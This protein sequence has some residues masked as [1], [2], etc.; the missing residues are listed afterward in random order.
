MERRKP[1]DE[2]ARQAIKQ[3]VE[4]ART[5]FDSGDAI[6]ALE[7]LR[8]A[9]DGSDE[10]PSAE[11]LE[12]EFLLFSIE[13]HYLPAKQN[14]S[15]IATLRQLATQL[16]D[17][18]SLAALHLSAARHE[19]YQGLV[20]SAR[21]HLS[22]AERLT[23]NPLI[24][25]LLC[26]CLLVGASIEMY[27][28]CLRQALRASRLGFD[29]ALRGNLKRHK[30]GSLGNLGTLS[31]CLGDQVAARRLLREGLELCDTL[32]FVRLALTDSLAATAVFDGN[33]AEAA[34][35][36][37]QCRQTIATQRVP[38]RSW[39]DLTHQITRCLF[40]SL[41]GEW[42]NIVAI[43]DEA[44]PELERRHLRT[45]RATLLAARAKALARLGQHDAANTSLVGAM[46]ACPKGAVDPM[47]HVETA[48][49]VCLAHRG[50]VVQAQRH[51]DRA[52]R[53]C[54]AIEHR[55]LGWIAEHE[56]ANSP[57]GASQ[58][59]PPLERRRQADTD[60][61]AL[62]L[63]NAAAI[64]NAGRSLDLMAERV[65][66]LLHDTPL[67]TRVRL[68]ER[69]EG[70]DQATSALTASW[71]F[72]GSQ[73]CRIDLSNNDRTITIDV[74]DLAS[75]EEVA[76]VKSVTDLLGASVNKD[77]DADERLWPMTMPNSPDDT[78]FWSPRMQELLRITERLATTDLPIL[79]TGETGTGKEVFARLIHDSSKVRRGPF[80]P[81]NASAIPRDLVE[82]QL[83]GHRRGAFT[84]AHESSAGVIRSAD[85]GTLFLDEI[86]DLELA[87]QPKLLR[88]LECG[89]VHPV[90]DAKPMRVSVRV[91]AATNARLETM[92]EQGRFRSDLLYRLRVAALSLPPLR[93]RKD[94][95]PAL[96]A[97]FVRKAMAECGRHHI[98][99]GDD[100][101][102]AFLL[103]D[104][105]GNLR[106]LYNEIRRMV[107]VA[108]D[109]A[110][111]RSD[112][113][114]H[115]VAGPWHAAH[116]RSDV[117]SGPHVTVRLDQPLEL[118]VD[119][120]ERAFI[121]RALDQTRGKVTDAAQ[122]LGISRKGLF[123]KRK[124]L[125]L[126]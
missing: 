6:A 83:F 38:A 71:E 110:T 89:E 112:D 65:R 21:S 74:Q 36:I 67:R 115:D 54:D 123:V 41:R 43:V 85:H 30:A 82:S 10:A 35:L 93:E 62:L 5:T 114:S 22:I 55:F 7:I 52:A 75:L 45:W 103:Y 58:G 53:A 1:D 108:D 23:T 29:H 60:N 16:G 44:D 2:S 105:P 94:E 8:C 49:A 20:A 106:Q 122:L 24:P 15:G 63:S 119:E 97:F 116:P 12:A 92:V 3:A 61:S 84:G 79:I 100:V 91:V 96:T 14:V 68:S 109:E 25:S 104:W 80:V 73:G 66:S 9:S 113:L 32:S 11:R 4:Q 70:H 121:E 51:F 50:D 118:A 37:E 48:T 78:V 28:G 47:I 69:P 40:H 124:R 102:A 46:S 34:D 87:L 72:R 98:T 57:G 18:R 76:I 86:G 95:I 101:V 59:A 26:S 77:D 17:A 111:L 42:T 13:E 107:A 88:F 64:L 99:V 19:G 39:Y 56:R 125:G 81:F 126:D 117:P 31:L 120:V 90:G 33:L 27:E